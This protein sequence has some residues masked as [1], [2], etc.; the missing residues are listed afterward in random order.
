MPFRVLHVLDHSWP[1]LDGYAQRSRSI[2][3]AQSQLGMHPSVLTSPL[4]QVDDP[5]APAE[6]IFEGIRYIR[7]SERNGLTGL[8]IQKRFPILRELAVISRLRKKVV[9]ILKNETFDIVHAHSPALCGLAASLAARACNV[10]FVY[11]IRA[12]WEDGAVDQNRNKET[13][14][15]YR[16]SK[17]LETNVVQRANAVVGIARPILDDLEGRGVQPAKLFHVPNGVDVARF[18]SQPRDASL[19]AE[20][21]VDGVRTL[22]FLGTLFLWEGIAWLISAAAELH[23]RGV[24][25]KLLIVGD[26]PDAENV[27]SAIQK[28]GAQNYIS[29]LG[30][31]PNDQVERYYSLMDV[32]LYPRRSIRLTEL[33]TPLKPLEAMALGKPVL[34]SGVGGIRELVEPETTGLLFQPGNIDSFCHQATRLLMD[35]ELGRRLGSQARQ[36]IV[37]EKDWKTIVQRYQRVYEFARSHHVKS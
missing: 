22:G 35:E 13:S 1:V 7:T 31:V 2:V 11:E 33:V 27:K 21:G 24:V 8:A 6:S 19:A 15:R 23:K 32:M 30:R 29:F 12:F 18:S 20:L 36:M 37:E 28:A 10:P 4:H 25:F 16:V 5:S 9:F 3:T 34:G 17:N 26:G 14:L